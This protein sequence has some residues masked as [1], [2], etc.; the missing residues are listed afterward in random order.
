MTLRSALQSVT[1]SR[2]YPKVIVFG[3]FSL[4]L[5]RVFLVFALFLYIKAMGQGARG[6]DPL[7]RLIGC[8]FPVIPC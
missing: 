7:T 1:K 5:Y 4:N 8:S 2:V 6:S 3:G